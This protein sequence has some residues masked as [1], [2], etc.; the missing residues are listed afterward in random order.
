MPVPLSQ[1]RLLIV[2]HWGFDGRAHTGQLVVNRDVAA[3]LETCS[4]GSTSFASRSDT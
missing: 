1:L 2:R 4:D 3:A